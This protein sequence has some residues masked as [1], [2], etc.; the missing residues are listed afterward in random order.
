MLRVCN[1]SSKIQTAI[2]KYDLVVGITEEAARCTAYAGGVA[3]V[4]GLGVE[5]AADS[6]FPPPDPATML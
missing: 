1:K 6:S 2:E 3:T 5:D 4:S